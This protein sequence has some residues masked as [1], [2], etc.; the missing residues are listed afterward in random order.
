M[1]LFDKFRSTASTNASFTLQ[2]ATSGVLL[3]VV[4]SDG[5]ISDDE[6]ALFNLI[7][8]R[9]PVFRDQ[10]AAEYGRMIDKMLGILKREGWSNLVVKCC[11][12]LPQE[13]KATVFAL[14]VD[15]VFADG[16][17]EEEEKELVSFLQK[18]LTFRMIL[19][20][21]LSMSLQ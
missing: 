17:V 19:P 15:F 4:A 9:H 1:G 2:E 13:F 12:D 7:A 11:L 5:N 8:T 6:V 18:S 20:A 21:R 16:S 10:P 3:S 14:G